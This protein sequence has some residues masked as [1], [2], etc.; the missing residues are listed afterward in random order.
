LDL[1]RVLGNESEP[2]EARLLAAVT[3]GRI[4]RPE[5]VHVLMKHSGIRDE[6]VS[7]VI[8]ASLGRI[9]DRSAVDI[10]ARR[11][12]HTGPAGDAARFAAVLLAHRYG[13]DRG[14]PPHFRASEYIAVPEVGCVSFHVGP[15]EEEEAERCIRSLESRPLGVEFSGKAAY[16]IRCWRTVKMLLIN[17]AVIAEDAAR[18]MTTRKAFLGVVA[19]RHRATG[20]YGATNLLLTS[21]ITEGDADGF[22][23]FLTRLSGRVMLRG[24]AQT[25][26][27]EADCLLRAVAGSGVRPTEVSLTFE[28]G[29]IQ[30]HRAITAP[31][32]GAKARAVRSDGSF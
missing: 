4:P 23:I 21:P 5:A 1:D 3:L 26:G 16:E 22:D 15:A 29:R 7:A 13:L 27:K 8:M 2:R 9:G 18:R 10:V 12:D 17:R 24:S 11:N 19:A 31:F 32:V 28:S 30:V 20:S 25:A 6:A 14:D